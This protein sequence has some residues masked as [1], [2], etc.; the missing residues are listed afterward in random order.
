MAV[1]ASGMN[2]VRWLA[3]DFNG[4]KTLRPRVPRVSPSATDSR[5]P[6]RFEATDPQRRHLGPAE[7]ERGSEPHH[8]AVALG[9]LRGDATTSSGDRS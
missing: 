8:R 6:T 5:P 2:M 3:F 9:E 1:I 7:P 4:A